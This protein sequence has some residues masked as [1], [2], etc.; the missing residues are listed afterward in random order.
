VAA[1]GAY[2]RAPLRPSMPR[3]GR[4]PGA[5]QEARPPEPDVVV[6][7]RALL[8]GR[9][10]PVDIGIDEDGFIVKVARHVAGRARR[11]F[12]EAILLPSAV[13]LHV[14]TREPG[15]EGIEDLRT[16]TLGAALGGV[17]LIGEMPNTEPPIDSPDRVDDQLGRIPRRA[18]VDVL[19]YAVA[20]PGP[21]VARLARRAG[22]FKL[23]LS[24][25]TGIAEP[26]VA[27]ELPRLL[28]AVADSRLALTVH[29]EAPEL[30]G[31]PR[32]ARELDGWDAARPERAEETAIDRLLGIAPPSL[33]LHVA[34]VTTAAAATR[35][36]AAGQSFEA[37][38]HHLLLSAT[39]S[40]DP[41]RK[42]NPPLRPEAT[43]RGLLAE[44]DAGRVPILASDH[45][46]HSA[47]AKAR[48]F[49]L[50]PSGVPGVE[51]ML[52]L[53]L[54]RVRTGELPLHVLQ[55]AASDRPA[56]WAGVPLGRISVGHRADLLVVDFRRRTTL[57][58]S[59]LHSPCGWTP[60]EGRSA[61][62]PQH[63]LRG[64]AFIVQDGEYVGD[65]EGR[66]VRPDFVEGRLAA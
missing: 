36:R 37:S 1:R 24:P 8:R 4:G 51:T 55:S 18:A 63:H 47:D 62:F 35:L 20:R 58:G 60:F 65:R 5:R 7:G 10:Q 16:A 41:R 9:L 40:T 57:R 61:V 11:D 21:W 56:R 33:R 49:A 54:D 66:A 12:G 14:H 3:R 45:A 19:V 17:G 64:G 43:R 28:R 46:P 42:V 30:F 13:D 29:A 39:G 59:A 22:A 32:E 53:F 15:A 6:A 31:S 34:H 48:P 52:P 27:E 38:P 50:A 26:P 25:T 2:P 44:F 23:Y